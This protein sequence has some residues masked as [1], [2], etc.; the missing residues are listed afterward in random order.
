MKGYL[1]NRSGKDIKQFKDPKR[2]GDVFTVQEILDA[3]GVPALDTTEYIPNRNESI[4]SSGLAFLVLID[5]KNRVKDPSDLIYSYQ[6]IPLK[7]EYKAEQQVIAFLRFS[8][9]PPSPPPPLL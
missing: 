7:S 5:Y 1:W 2:L 3:A 8:P 4:R 6:F 9:P